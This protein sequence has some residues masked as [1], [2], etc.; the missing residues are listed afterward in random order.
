MKKKEVIQHNVQEKGA[1]DTT[2][3]G[4]CRNVFLYCWTPPPLNLIF[5]ECCLE[6]TFHDVSSSWE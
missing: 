2:L 4:N 6:I 5:N 1:K 3:G